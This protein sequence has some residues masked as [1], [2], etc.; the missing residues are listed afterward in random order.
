MVNIPLL[1][2]FY[3]SQV[4]VWDFWTINSIIVTLHPFGT[5]PIIPVSGAQLRLVSCNNKFFK[6]TNSDCSS[7]ALM[8][9]LQVRWRPRFAKR[10]VPSRKN[11]PNL[12][13]FEGFDGS[14]PIFMIFSG[15]GQRLSKLQASLVEVEVVFL[16]HVFPPQ[17]WVF[18]KFFGRLCKN[19]W[20]PL[21]DLTTLTNSSQK[22]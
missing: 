9:F 4:V 18:W 3:T 17:K 15:F 5:A 10:E 2:G 19:E 1:T 22:Q 16:V 6:A 11:S 12:P 20:K 14:F 8:K 13:N 21:K 7:T